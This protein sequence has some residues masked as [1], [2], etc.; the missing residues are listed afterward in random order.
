MLN[1]REFQAGPDPFGRTYQVLLKW[2]QT[3]ISIRHSDTVDVRFVL[4]CA[5]SR[6]EKTVALRHAELVKLGREAGREITDA[7][8][9]RLAALHLKYL[10]E[11]GEDLEKD[12]VTVG[13]PQLQG[14]AAE[15]AREEKADI[16]RRG[17][18]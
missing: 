10:V 8:C 11:T 7:W 9:S 4:Q 18:A 5:G 3:A 1:F 17:A 6:T 16:A 13:Y 15:L 14:Y 2:M 12:P